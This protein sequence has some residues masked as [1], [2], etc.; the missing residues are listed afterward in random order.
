M[1]LRK[2]RLLQ[3]RLQSFHILQKNLK[4]NNNMFNGYQ[5]REWLGVLEAIVQH[6]VRHDGDRQ[7]A[8]SHPEVKNLKGDEDHWFRPI[9]FA[10][11]VSMERENKAKSGPMSVAW[12][13]KLGNVRELKFLS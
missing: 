10:K 7:L 9:L 4:I 5:L 11:A 12:F 1:D 13:L 2:S 3:N 8:F 6:V